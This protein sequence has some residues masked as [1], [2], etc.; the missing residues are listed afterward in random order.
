MDTSNVLT[1]LRIA[2][3]VP[4][5]EFG[6]VVDL[7]ARLDDHLGS[8]PDGAVELQLTVNERDTASQRTVLE[9]RIA[10]QTTIV[11]TSR[12]NDLDAALFEVRDELVRQLVDAKDQAE[13]R[14]RHARQS[15]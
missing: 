1:S 4:Q 14:H 10:G 11:A 9:A 15:R 8:F 12:L 13:P 5:A 2:N 3:G 6:H 7:L